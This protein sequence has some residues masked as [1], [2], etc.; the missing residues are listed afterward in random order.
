MHYRVGLIVFLSLF[1]VVPGMF[2]DGHH[3]AANVRM[4]IADEVTQWEN[5]GVFPVVKSGAIFEHSG[6]TVQ[7]AS[8][9]FNCHDIAQN[10]IDAQCR[11]KA[12]RRT[13]QK[14][15][16]KVQDLCV[17]AVAYFLF[18]T[19]VLTQS[20]ANKYQLITEYT[21]DNFWLMILIESCVSVLRI[22]LQYTYSFRIRIYLTKYNI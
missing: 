13:Q 2:H 3:G 17:P 22:V 19:Q 6:G 5:F 8:L 16:A 15:A 20:Q 18:C 14:S 11:Y 7:Y 21:W 10:R 12:M 1:H 9:T 4:D